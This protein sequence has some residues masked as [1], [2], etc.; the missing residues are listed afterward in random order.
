MY[1]K[2]AHQLRAEAYRNMVRKLL[3]ALARLLRLP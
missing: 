3:A 1:K 2:R